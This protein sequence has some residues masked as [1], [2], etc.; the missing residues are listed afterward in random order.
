[1]ATGPTTSQSLGDSLQYI[2]NEARMVREYGTVMTRVVDKRTLP[3]N[4]GR[5]WD[6]ISISRLDPAQTIDED[7]DLQN[8]QQFVDTLFSVEPVMTGIATFITDKAKAIVSTKTLAETGQG[9]QNAIERRKDADGLIVLDSGVSFGGAGSTLTSGIIS[10]A[11]T[12][13]AFGNGVEA[14]TGRQ[15]AVIHS[16]QMKDL[17][18][19]VTSGVGTYPTPNGLT[20]EVYRQGFQGSVDGVEIFT[21]DLLLID[22]ADD[23][24]GGCFAAGKGGAIVYVQGPGKKLKE[25]YNPAR[26]GGGMEVYAYDDYG[27]GIR[28]PN[29]LAELYSDATAVTS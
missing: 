3:M 28:L 1:M 26:G 24:K 14:W 25:R 13:N 10:A 16:R 20:E 19:E 21:D 17:R 2:E 22:S 15:V 11:Q 29:S 23:V 18:D 8:F 5:T 27:W 6:E 12:E 7:T 9:M 4:Q